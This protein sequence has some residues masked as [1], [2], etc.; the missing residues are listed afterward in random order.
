MT[1]RLSTLTLGIA[2]A[3]AMGTATAKPFKWASAGEISTWDIH[4][5]NNALQNGIHAAVYESLVY[6]NSRSFKI[7]PVLA[8][9]WREVSATQ[10][11]ITLREGVKFHDGTPFTADDAVYSIQRAM[12]KTS[13]FAIYTQGI[14]RVVKVNANTIDIITKGPNPVMLNQLTELRMMSKAWAEKNKSVDPK[15][16]KA[17]EET[18]A[19]RNAMGTGPYLLKEWLPDQRMVFERNPNYWGKIDSNVTQITYTPIKSDATRMA[20]LLSGEVDLVL[21]PT[22]QDLP[23]LRNT[24]NLKVIDGVENR[25]IFLGMDQ[26]RNELV[27]SNVKGKNPLKDVRVRKALYQAI[28]IDTINRVT[29]R[30]LSQPTGALVAPQVAGW[31]ESV[32]QRFPFD[33]AAAQKLLADAG[34]KDGFEVDFACPNNRYINDEQICQ[35]VASMWAKIGVKAK[36]R[37]L[38]L[39]T[40][41]PMIQ[42]YE[43][44]IYMLGWGV[45][46][47]DALYSVQSL[48]RSVGQGGDGN[49]NLGRYSSPKMDAIIDR[50]KTETDPF[51]RPR[52]LTEALQLQNDDVAHIPLHNQIIPWAMKR[53]VDVVH[54]A[55]NRI[56][57]RLVKVN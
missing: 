22:P 46:T 10:L 37:T 21:D 17:T 12:A 29:M 51:I 45:P 2:M 16:I 39:V 24:S 40:Y 6:Y 27:G 28:D 13:N 4:S 5:Q 43:A 56:D 52:L 44:S 34:Y 36:L 20:A 8:T 53:S 25:T 49:Y 42:R 19:H 26:H 7:E 38:P 33:A 35:A 14:D 31:S 41:F 55:D 9:A 54:R 15:D 48:V 50:A 1:F 3:V 57:W 18:F 30:G 23:R 32:H 11:R 47:F